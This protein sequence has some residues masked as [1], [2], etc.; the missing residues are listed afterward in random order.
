MQKIFLENV[1]VEKKDSFVI[2]LFHNINKDWQSNRRWENELKTAMTEKTSGKNLAY[3]VINQ[4]TVK[5]GENLTG[6]SNTG[7]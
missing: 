5:T 3:L 7:T 6:R 1:S 4:L 2:V